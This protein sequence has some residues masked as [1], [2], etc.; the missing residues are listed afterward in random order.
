M[1]LKPCFSFRTLIIC[2]WTFL[3]SHPVYY[4]HVV[5]VC[6]QL[7]LFTFVFTS[8]ASVVHILNTIIYVLIYLNYL[9][10]YL[11]SYCISQ[12]HFRAFLQQLN[13]QLN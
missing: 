8:L 4:C 1:A 5:F 11:L 2:I 9:L 7:L 3:T 6:N 13:R 10:T 12:T